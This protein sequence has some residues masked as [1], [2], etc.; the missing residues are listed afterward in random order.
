MVYRQQYHGAD[1]PTIANLISPPITPTVT[2]LE[3]PKAVMR[4]IEQADQAAPQ[5]GRRTKLD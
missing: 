3:L 2:P 1:G 4:H 5:L